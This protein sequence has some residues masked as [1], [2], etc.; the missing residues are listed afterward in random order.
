MALTKLFSSVASVSSDFT[1]VL[2]I[3]QGF[4]GGSM[5]KKICNAGDMNEVGGDVDRKTSGIYD[6]YLQEKHQSNS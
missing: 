5:V 2:T 3:P 6:S 4:P 1:A